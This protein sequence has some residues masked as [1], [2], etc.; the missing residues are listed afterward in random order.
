M[1]NTQNPTPAQAFA[2]VVQKA[3]DRVMTPQT[4]VAIPLIMILG[5]A[6]WVL[7]TVRQRDMDRLGA[8]RDAIRIEVTAVREIAAAADARAQDL[9]LRVTRGELMQ[10]HTGQALVEM[11]TDI[12]GILVELREMRREAKP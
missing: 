5:V 11:K 12:K 10:Q 2:T 4:K 7:D 8:E 3:A 9:L 1:S 6:W